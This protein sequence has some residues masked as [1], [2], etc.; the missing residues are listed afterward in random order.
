M[1][2]L[3]DVM[4]EEDLFAD[5]TEFDDNAEQGADEAE[6]AKD[7]EE[8]KKVE[9][10]KRIIRNPQPKLN[11]DRLRGPRGLATLQ[12]VFEDVRFKG[13]NHEKEYLDK[14]MWKLEHWCHRLY[15]KL[16]Y[17]ECLYRIEKLGNKKLVRT[18]MGK[19]RQGLVDLDEIA[20]DEVVE[21]VPDVL[22]QEDEFDN[23]LDQQIAQIRQE[24][25]QPAPV[26]LTDEQIERMR[27]NQEAA[28][29]R[30]RAKRLAQQLQFQ[31]YENIDNINIET[32]QAV[33]N[34][35]GDFRPAEDEINDLLNQPIAQK[36]QEPVELT[37]EQKERMRKNQEAAR[38][39]LKA[40]RLAQQMQQE[41]I[42]NKATYQKVAG[43]SQEINK[44]SE[45]NA[46]E[47]NLVSSTVASI[48]HTLV[49]DEANQIN[50]SPIASTNRIDAETENNIEEMDINQVSWPIA[51]TNH[52]EDGTS[53]L[54]LSTSPAAKNSRIESEICVPETDNNIEEMEI[55]PVV[56]IS[57]SGGDDVEEMQITPVE[58]IS[59]TEVPEVLPN[60]D[61]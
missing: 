50:S 17:D 47:K 20:N 5:P 45:D 53:V 36:P 13:K 49:D 9:P 58:E 4:A 55:S 44:S 32:N 42:D 2:L 39:R 7:G 1:S 26:Q 15:P 23:L 56:D 41:N 24:P 48:S 38:E 16:Q 54:G 3:E 22:P 10:K 28:R 18:Y 46:V 31:E 14:I 43:T 11:A 21:D 30:L 60:C 6:E 37:D 61:E 40:K 52:T 35:E 19:L 8:E 59:T 57:V 12:K 29:E 27:K 25:V 34:E 33:P 51:S